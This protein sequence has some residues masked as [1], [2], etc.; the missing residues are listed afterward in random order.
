MCY[1]NEN[2]VLLNVFTIIFLYCNINFISSKGHS[3]ILILTIK[4]FDISTS[5]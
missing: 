3:K 5:N 1:F 4:L 2:I